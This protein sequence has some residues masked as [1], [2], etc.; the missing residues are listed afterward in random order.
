MSHNYYHKRFLNSKC[1]SS[2]LALFARYKGAWKEVTESMACLETAKKYIHNLKDY[3][4]VVVGDGCSPR[5]GA[6][7]AYMT[8]ATVISVD[9]NFNEEH[10]LQFCKNQE[11]IGYPVER[12]KIVKDYIENCT[13]DC[14]GKPVLVIWPHSHANMNHCHVYNFTKRID[15]AMPC[16]KK[17][18]NGWMNAPH[19]TFRDNNI[20][21]PKNIFHIWGILEELKEVSEDIIKEEIDKYNVKLIKDITEA[22]DFIDKEAQIMKDC[23]TFNNKFNNNEV[24]SEYWR[25][26]RFAS[27]LRKAK[28]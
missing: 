25:L 15:I 5:T 28:G 14:E 13:I 7:F 3:H 4:V 23:H 26:K 9:P 10:Y 27:G 22:A 6:L 8:K 24:E 19:I 17:I 11:A 20:L 16:C 1:S 18:P 21:S 12:L 2:I